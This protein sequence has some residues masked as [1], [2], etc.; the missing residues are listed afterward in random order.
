MDTLAHGLL[1]YTI[2]RV[3]QKPLR[4]WWLLVG[5]GM[6]PDAVWIVGSVF[7][8]PFD[9]LYRMSHSLTVWAVIST[10]ALLI[11]RRA[12]AFTWPWALHILVDIPGH[13]VA[14]GSELMAKGPL[15]PFLWPLSDFTLRGWWNWLDV[16]WIVG[17]YFGIGI[18]LGIVEWRRRRTFR[19]VVDSR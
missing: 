5:F 14:S 13:T 8:I 7:G 15:T 10:V 12:F 6:L 2:S 16:R 11:T 9:A 3:P 17:T 19:H 1:T 4:S 18:T